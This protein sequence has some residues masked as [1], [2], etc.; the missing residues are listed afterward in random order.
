MIY[1][2]TKGD[3]SDYHIV[4]ATV[5]KETAQRIAERYEAD[6]EKYEDAEIIPDK[7]IWMVRVSDNACEAYETDGDY[8]IPDAMKSKIYPNSKLGYVTLWVFADDKEHAEKI[9]CDKYAQWKHNQP[10]GK[11]YGGVF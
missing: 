8:A 5:S 6:I 10:I 9:A 2:L 11:I 7:P 4:A 3:Y 1:V